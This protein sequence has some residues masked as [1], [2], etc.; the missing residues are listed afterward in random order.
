MEL[1]REI[2]DTALAARYDGEP[3][4]QSFRVGDAGYAWITTAE[5]LAIPG[6]GRPWVQARLLELRS[7]LG[8]RAFARAL[9]SGV[10][11]RASEPAELPLA[12]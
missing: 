4:V 3:M 9:A 6:F 10:R 12:A 8:P 1:V 7:A 5:A 11:L 2:P